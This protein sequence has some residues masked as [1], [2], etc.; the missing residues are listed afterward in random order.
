MS[1]ARSRTRPP[2]LV[3]LLH[4]W[5]SA[6]KRSAVPRPE[7]RRREDGIP[8][9]EVGDAAVDD[10]LHTFGDDGEEGYRPVVLGD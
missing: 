6:S 1:T 3:F 7:L 10:G 8:L 9:E 5:W 2:W 4:S